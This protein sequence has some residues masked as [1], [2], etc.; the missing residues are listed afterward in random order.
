MRVTVGVC[1]WNRAALLDQTL[2]RMQ[3]LEIPS[4]VDWELLVVNNNCTDETDQVLQKQ[5]QKLPLRRLSEPRPGLARARNCV[6]DEA[7]GDLLLWTDDDVLVDPG[8]LSAYVDAANAW[9]DATYFGGPIEPWFQSEPPKWIHANLDLVAG[10][11]ALLN[12]GPETRLLVAPKTPFGA[13]MGMRAAAVRN[14]RFNPVLGKTENQILPGEETTFL[15]ALAADGHAG[16]WVGSA[17]V[18][19]YVPEQRLKKDRIVRFFEEMG[20]TEVMIEGV[21]GTRR[22]RGVPLYMIRQYLRW[23]LREW[24]LAPFQTRG[25]VIAL[26]RSCIAR[27]KIRELLASRTVPA[28]E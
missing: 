14:R 24:A 8:W 21:E 16:L 9:P 28:G 26:I 25:W 20:K 2:S 4:G 18:R 1:T 3:A 23:Q 12:Y 7:Q 11:F 5:G 27:G 13:N 6:M 15:R 17:R 19:H 10:V 22:I